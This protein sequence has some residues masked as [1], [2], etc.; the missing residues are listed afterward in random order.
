MRAAVVRRDAAQR[1]TPARRCVA[2]AC[3]RPA[4]QPQGR[5]DASL[6]SEQRRLLAAQL[7][8]AAQLLPVGAEALPSVVAAVRRVAGLA[9]APRRLS[10]ACG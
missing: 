8:Q 1:V 9:G 7:V 5:M 4:F 3:R 6:S 10:V 2:P